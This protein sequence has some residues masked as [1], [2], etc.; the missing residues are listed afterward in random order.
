MATI[1]VPTSDVLVESVGPF[2]TGIMLQQMLMGVLVVQVY[3]YFRIFSKDPLL[4]KALVSSLLLVSVFQ[5]VLDFYS[6]YRS[7]ITYYG[8][9]ERFNTGN[10]ALWSEI[11]LTALVGALSQGFFLERCFAATKS[12]L[13]LAGGGIAI[14]AS[15]CAGIVASI[16][17]G[18]T[19]KIS[20]MSSLTLSMALWL[21][22]SAVI[23]ILISFILITKLTLAKT[24]FKRTEAIIT[25]IVR[26]S[27]TTS[28]L[29]AAVTIVEVALYL[30]LPNKGWHLLPFF[31]L[32]KIYAISVLVTL[33]SRSGLRAMMEAEGQAIPTTKSY[34]VAQRADFL[35]TP[36]PDV[37]GIQVSTTHTYHVDRNS[38][39]GPDDDSYD[40][41]I[42]KTGPLAGTF[43]VHRRDPSINSKRSFGSSTYNSK[44]GGSRDD[45]EMQISQHVGSPEYQSHLDLELDMQSLDQHSP[46]PLEPPPDRPFAP[47]PSQQPPRLPQPVSSRPG[48]GHSGDRTAM[49]PR[50]RLTILP[51]VVVEES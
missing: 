17:W 39:V 5:T 50:G 18:Q 42:T 24:E 11:A 2:V 34:T 31:V 20:E 49:S 15:L 33:S 28:A 25:R 19:K 40:T 44:K 1:Q 6:L 16:F 43:V 14:L 10:W 13:V 38:A 7:G 36:R 4:N 46:L 35:T 8:Q 26:L 9:F 32:G 41:D 45:I 29:T 27:F 48:S 21:I 23:G 37:T 3:D 30:A 22:S 47:H 51:V 12:W